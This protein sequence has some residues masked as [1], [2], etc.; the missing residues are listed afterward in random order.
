MVISKLRMGYRSRGRLHPWD[1]HTLA[2]NPADADIV[3][4][5][6]GYIHQ[7]MDESLV[8][9][10]QAPPMGDDALLRVLHYLD[11]IAT[12]APRT[13]PYPFQRLVARTAALHILT[14][15]LWGDRGKDCTSLHPNAVMYTPDYSGLLIML[16]QGKTVSSKRGNLRI[17]YLPLGPTVHP[18]LQWPSLALALDEE[19]RLHGRSFLSQG[20]VFADHKASELVGPPFPRWKPTRSNTLIARALGTSSQGETCYSLRIHA[21]SRSAI[22]DVRDLDQVMANHQWASR[23]MAHRYTRFVV[24][25]RQMLAPAANSQG[26]ASGRLHQAT[27]ATALAEWRAQGTDFLFFRPPAGSQ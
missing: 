24:A 23:A 7:R 12:T 8:R 10:A 25:I 13:G 6:S 18:L 26:N 20:Y 15:S 19:L 16:F 4:A 5:Y 11:E 2:P 27:W 9:P 3:T 17:I 21:S 22:E 14:C 1:E